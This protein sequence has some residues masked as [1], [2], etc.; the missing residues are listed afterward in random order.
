MYINSDRTRSTGLSPLNHTGDVAAVTVYKVE[1]YVLAGDVYSNPAHIGRGGWTWY[2]G[3]AGWM[4]QLISESLL[5]LQRHGSRLRMRSL[6]P[7]DWTT[8]AMQYHFGSS[9]YDITCHSVKAAASVSVVL[10]G[11]K[12]DGDTLTLIDDGQLHVV[13]VNFPQSG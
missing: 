3:S 8:F 1:P 13:T 7:S 4:L 2:T 5:G 9:R 6:L 10:D 12:I 11:L